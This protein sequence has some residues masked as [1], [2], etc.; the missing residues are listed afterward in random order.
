MEGMTKAITFEN[1][2]ILIVIEGSGTILTK[3]EQKNITK[4]CILFLVP[5]LEFKFDLNKCIQLFIC[6]A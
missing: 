5:N 6:N 3:D 2:S 1:P 4:G